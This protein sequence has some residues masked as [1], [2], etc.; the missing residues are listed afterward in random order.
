MG[1]GV[2]VVDSQG[3]SVSAPLA[4]AEVEADLA[5]GGEAEG[6]AAFLQLFQSYG[7]GRVGEMLVAFR[8]GWMPLMSGIAG[9][10]GRGGKRYSVVT[11]HT[12]P[13]VAGAGVSA[14]QL[15]IDFGPDS[16]F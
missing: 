12:Q 15:E 14:P 13:L 1:F 2:I 9:D 4:P 8:E 16:S 6:I 10:G 3:D 5:P 11:V 7:N